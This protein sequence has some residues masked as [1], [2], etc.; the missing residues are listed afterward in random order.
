MW[1]LMISHT[2]PDG[3]R[4]KSKKDVLDTK[5]KAKILEETKSKYKLVKGR[6]S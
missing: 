1:L 5:I 2:K 3:L 6:S 4:I